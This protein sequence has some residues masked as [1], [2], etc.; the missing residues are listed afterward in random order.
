MAPVIHTLCFPPMQTFPFTQTHGRNFPS[1]SDDLQRTIKFHNHQR[2]FLQTRA[3][4]LSTNLCNRDNDT[5]KTNY[6]G[7]LVITAS[8]TK[9]ESLQLFCQACYKLLQW[10]TCCCLGSLGSLHPLVSSIAA[11]L[12]CPDCG[13][14]SRDHGRAT[15][16][17]GGFTSLVF[18]PHSPSNKP[19]GASPLT[20]RTSHGE[21]MQTS[22]GRCV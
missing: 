2:N 11:L 19:H 4:L 14:R 5:S 18:R 20:Q 10:D 13:S 8:P 3:T 9:K 1:T 12:Q 22:A 6:A 15:I 7:S 21:P 17:V 16:A